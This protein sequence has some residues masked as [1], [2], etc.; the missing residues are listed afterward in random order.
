M[1]K[2]KNKTMIWAGILFAQIILFYGFSKSEMIIHWHQKFFE[3]QKY[4]HQLLF[5]WLPF[6]VG[7]VFYLLLSV[8]IFY[9][10]IKIKTFKV[11]F[12]LL[13]NLF[14]FLYQIFWGLLYFQTPL[15]EKLP[16]NSI[17]QKEIEKLTWKYLD[18][19]KTT[20]ELTT[21]DRNGIFFINDFKE[22]EQEILDQQNQIPHI[23]EVQKPTHIHSIK[24][25]LF[26]TAMNYTGILGYYNPF[27]AEAQYNP[28]LPHSQIPFTIAHETAHQLGIAREQEAHFWAYL[29]GTK[30]ENLD[31]KYSTYWFV[32]KSLIR[33]Q[34]YENP[35]FAD[36][37][38][39]HFSEKMK[40]DLQ[41]E[42]E[43]Y[44]KYSGLTSETLHATND[45]FLKANQQDGSIS[46]DYF[47]HLFLLYEKASYPKIE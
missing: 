33:F 25:S 8:L 24:P 3:A 23:F 46:Y 2:L 38:F 40:N 47:L 37:I 44:E 16:Q 7:D 42:R 31:L 28:N 32:L 36:E 6:S 9:F 27:T 22:I 18:L 15:I 10:S 17:S 39:N 12:L 4:Y 20:R 29:I 21:E 35:D 19:C 30:S 14:Y 1:I 43:F 13:V 26:A 11:K 34:A 45:L 41:N 5:S